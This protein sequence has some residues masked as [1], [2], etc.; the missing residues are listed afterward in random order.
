M[1]SVFQN[2]NLIIFVIQ[3]ILEKKLVKLCFELYYIGGEIKSGNYM[4]G[5]V[6]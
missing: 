5:M 4:S 6:A 2:F 1:D 3:F